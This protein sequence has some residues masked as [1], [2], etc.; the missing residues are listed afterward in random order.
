MPREAFSS[1]LAPGTRAS[2]RRLLARVRAVPGVR[3]A[4]G[5]L[6]DS[7][8][9]VIGGEAGLHGLRPVRGLV[10]RA[11]SP[12]TPSTTS[13][14]GR[15]GG[16]AR[17]SSIAGGRRPGPSRRPA[18]RA[19]HALRRPAGRHLRHR[20]VGGRDVARRRHDRRAAARR[21][22]A[23]VPASRRAVAHRR[24]PPIA[25]SRP[26]S[27]PPRCAACCRARDREDGRRGRG[28]DGRHRQRGDRELPH[29]RRC[30]RCREPR[31]SWA[32]SSSSTH[33]RSRS[34]SGPASSR[35]C[36][37]WASTRRQ[38]LTAVAVEALAIGV[39]ASVL[40]LFAGLGV[41]A[42]PRRAVRRRARHALERAGALPA[43]RSNRGWAS[44]S[45]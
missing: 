12:S 8:A 44:A 33:S 4:E 7:G 34:P 25:A 35:C 29:A 21:R 24:S 11:E 27:W 22:P 39:A 2:T 43:A 36:A 32:P 41:A 16:P 13:R 40:G 17:W 10:W 26:R 30:S 18:R 42:A 37:R 19:Q 38:V 45:A 28:Q 23:L 20:G 6:T 5:Q 1:D 9:L 15:R 31:C 3:L 14:A